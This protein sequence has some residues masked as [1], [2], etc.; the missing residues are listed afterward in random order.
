MKCIQ[1]FWTAKQDPLIY[2]F[3]WTHPEYNLM[4]WALSCLS[5]REHYDDV[6]LYTDSAG[7][8]VLIE[9]LKLPYTKTHVIFDDFDCLPQHWALSKIKTY[10]LQT[11]PFLHIDGDIYLPHPLPEDLMHAPLIAQ[12]KEIGTRYYR[13]MMNCILNME[14][15]QL[16]DFIMKCLQEESIASY[17]MGFFGGHD[18]DFIQKY[19]K[20]VFH[21]TQL[22]QINNCNS[23]NARVDCNVFFEQIIFAILADHYNKNVTGVLDHPMY[24]NGYTVSDFC[25][26]DKYE[27]Q[28]FFHLLGGHKKNKWAITMLEKA[29]VRIYP[30]VY[31]KIVSM[32]PQRYTQ[33]AERTISE[34]HGNTLLSIERSIAQWEDYMQEK[35]SEWTKIPC[36]ELF[37]LEKVIACANKFAQA[38][39]ETQKQTLLKSNPY[40]K[41]FHIPQNWNPKA[42][43]LLNST[44]KYE[45]DFHCS[46]IAS[47]PTLRTTE[48]KSKSL[49]NIELLIIQSFQKNDLHI[50]DILNR[51]STIY[52]SKPIKE[53]YYLKSCIIN[54][55][56]SL[57]KDGYIITVT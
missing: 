36:S 16:P 43:D 22:N 19:C 34:S 10:S 7:Y 13:N 40:I 46:I 27:E 47:I 15:L 9:V 30:S 42:F 51:L 57:V 53:Q 17:N 28:L 52:T 11:E 21:L 55:I 1:T 6:E 41:F 29:M 49:T 3:G 35:K 32:F 31:K 20:E 38:N 4:S 26:L 50:D 12:N 56:H 48:F 25:N 2:S 18:I 44:F 23:P 45:K 5:L 37:K 39:I 54:T 14:N 33:F 8:H 24:D